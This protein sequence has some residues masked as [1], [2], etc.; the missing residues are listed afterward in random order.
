MTRTCNEIKN[1]EINPQ[2]KFFLANSNLIN[3]MSIVYYIFLYKETYSRPNEIT[4]Y[5]E[6][7]QLK[8]MLLKTKYVDI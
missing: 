7:L 1:L 4:K 8:L 5:K 2:A 6:S 3:I